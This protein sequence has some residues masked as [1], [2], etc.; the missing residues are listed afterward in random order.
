VRCEVIAEGCELLL[1]HMVDTN[2]SRSGEQLAL[3]G[4]DSQFQAKVGDNPARMVSALEIALAAGD[5]AYAVLVKLPGDPER[6]RQYEVINLLDQL[7]HHPG[8]GG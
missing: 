3:A 8:G 6:I 1:G 2:S 4:I 5:T 7:R